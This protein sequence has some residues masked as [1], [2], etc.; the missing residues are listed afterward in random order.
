MS[1][2]AEHVPPFDPKRTL[3]LHNRTLLSRGAKVRCFGLPLYGAMAREALAERLG[4][5]LQG[6]VGNHR[7]FRNV[8]PTVPNAG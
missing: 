3:A 6:G 4:L 7:S 8:R 5:L 1:Y 2:W